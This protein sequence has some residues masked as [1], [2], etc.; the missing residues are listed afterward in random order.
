[1]KEFYCKYL[2]KNLW[3]HL[4]TF[5]AAALV[6]ASFFMPPTGVIDG[7]VLAALG[8]IF[9]FGALGTVIKAIDNG[10]GATVTHGGTTI[11]VKDID[12]QDA[13]P[14]DEF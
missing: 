14:V 12:G 2:L 6:T 11:E 8:E 4:L 7:S 5:F 13:A 3:F 10:V 9:A 1:M